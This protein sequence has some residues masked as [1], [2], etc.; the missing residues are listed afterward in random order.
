MSDFSDPLAELMRGAASDTGNDGSASAPSETPV[1]SP[2]TAPSP[3]GAASA[4]SA[5]AVATPPA[6]AAA[7]AA[8]PPRRPPPPAGPGGTHREAVTA[9]VQTAPRDAM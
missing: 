2:V 4:D 9:S 1:A 5:T 8:A 7:A 6:A 3:P